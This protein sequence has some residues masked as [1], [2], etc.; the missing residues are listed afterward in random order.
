MFIM[1]SFYLNWQKIPFRIF[2]TSIP[3]VVTMLESWGGLK[4]TLIFHSLEHLGF[5]S[6]TDF[7]IHIS[8]CKISF[9]WLTI[10]FYMKCHK[11]ILNI[12]QSLSVIVAGHKRVIIYIFLHYEYIQ[13]KRSFCQ[14]IIAFIDNYWSALLLTYWNDIAA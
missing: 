14:K 10:L 5:Y 13:E 9:F 12:L 7:V 6:N 2:F 3:V 4:Y 11:L 1:T 8:S